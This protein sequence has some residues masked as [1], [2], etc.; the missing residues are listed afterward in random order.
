MYRLGKKKPSSE[1]EERRLK[2]PKIKVHRELFRA[3]L[4]ASAA[5]VK[6]AGR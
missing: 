6:K 4:I 1:K 3:I 2:L 5:E